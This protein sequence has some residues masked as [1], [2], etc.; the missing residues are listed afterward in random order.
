VY[1]GATVVRGGAVVVGHSGYYRPYYASGYYHPYYAYR[2]YYAFHPHVSIGFGFWAG[3]PVPY[4]YYA[5]PYSYAYPYPYPAPAYS[6][7]SAYPAPSYNDSA[8]PYPQAGQSSV[9]PS[10]GYPPSQYP[11]QGPDYSAG[12]YAPPAGAQRGGQSASTG[13]VSFEVTPETAEVY[14]DGSFVGTAGSF[15]PRSQPLGLNAGRHR[16]EI[17]A[18]GYRTMTFDA[19][20][21]VGQ[22]IPYQGTLEHN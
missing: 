11:N 12:Q 18:S 14:V 13:G 9:Y 1:R 8:Q 20:V 17:R 2:P 22:V 4:P 21:Q 7:P 10:T 16:V 19:E 15:G 5:Y 3:Y 6:Y